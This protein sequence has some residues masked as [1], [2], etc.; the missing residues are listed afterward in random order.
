MVTRSPRKTG[1]ES[2]MFLFFFQA[3]RRLREEISG[4]VT[5][6]FG[7]GNAVVFHESLVHLG[8]QLPPLSAGDLQNYANNCKDVRVN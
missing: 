7:L 6:A 3:L 8:P 1:I 4:E 5:A 2:L